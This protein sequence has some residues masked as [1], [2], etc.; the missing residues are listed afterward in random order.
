MLQTKLQDIIS[1][2][3]YFQPEAIIAGG[4]MSILILGILPF[5]KSG[6]WVK[7]FALLILLA[8]TA[9][10]YQQFIS[11]S[12]PSN[13]L[14]LNMLRIES[15]G[16]L[17]KL[18]FSLGATLTV[19]MSIKN[20]Q[21]AES[22]YFAL[23]LSALLGA[24][25][26]VM[27]TNLLMIFISIELISLSSY[28]LTTFKMDKAG[29]EAGLKYLLF[30]AAASGI[31][32]FGMSWVYAFTGSLFIFESNF[33]NMLLNIHTVPLSIASLFIVAGLLFKASA[34]PM[35]IWAPDV[36]TAAPT[37]IVAFFSTVPKLAGIVILLKWIVVINIFGISET[38]WSSILALVAMVT[39]TIGNF[40][41]IWQTNIKRLMAYS[42]IAHSGFLL[43]AIVAFSESA[44]YTLI[45]Y[46]ITYVLM[47][48]CAFL[49]I[50]QLE[51]D[52]GLINIKDYRGLIKQSPLLTILILALMLSLAGLPP[53]GGF[54]AKLLIFSA[55]WESFATSGNSWMLYLLIFGLI[56]TVIALF[57]YLKIP[58][59][60]IFKSADIDTTSQKH[61][62]NWEN[63]LGLIMVVTLF[64]IF[65][66]PDGLM[67][68]INSV[69]FA[70]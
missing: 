57:Y 10:L 5:S 9:A 8:T 6:L 42:S 63:F 61:V 53:T 27:S 69:S 52:H 60:M 35:H 68:I 18:L 45:F 59:Y 38:N 54:T 28:A 66:K 29:A 30:G 2:L 22:E 41:A 16:I 39:I 34:A 13:G 12:I 64:L 40:S 55:L 58:Y 25:L 50:N 11:P 36:Y 4:I 70:F 24:N 65:F 49:F 7:S 23:L 19:L 21:K 51:R 14:F 3:A 32:I 37:P 15:S 62:F 67:R 33:V 20:E 46:A 44:A 26:L 56:N 31:M 47:N 1:S 43:V 17:W 48:M